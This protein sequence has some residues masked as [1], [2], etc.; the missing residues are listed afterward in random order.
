MDALVP[1]AEEGRGTLRKA[2]GSRVQAL[3]RGCPN[4]ETR[5]EKDSILR[6]N[7]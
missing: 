6:L 7:T 5:Y 4:G 1:D 2:S 3:I